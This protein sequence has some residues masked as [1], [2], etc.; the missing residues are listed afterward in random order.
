MIIYNLKIIVNIDIKIIGNNFYNILWSIYNIL[1]EETKYKESIISISNLCFYSE[2]L[3]YVNISIKWKNNFDNIT[4]VIQNKKEINLNW[5]IYN[6]KWIDFNFNI[7]DDKVNFIDFKQVEIIFKTPT[8]IKKE[9]NWIDINQLLPVPEV[10]LTSSIRKYNKLYNKEINIIEIKNIIKNNVIVVSFDIQTNITMIKKN[11]KAWVIW[12]VKYEIL[13]TID[14][15]T[16]YILYKSLKLASC[17]WVWTW[18][19]L[20]LGQLW[21]YFINK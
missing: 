18:V 17:I 6:I 2:W 14:N 8:I 13:D 7:F 19:K 12:K 4:Q 10:F 1:W 21:V 3:S 20:G 15:E 16:K 9:I 5:K 11:K